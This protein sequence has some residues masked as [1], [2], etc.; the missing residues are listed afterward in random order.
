MTSLWRH[1]EFK[2][3]TEKHFWIWRVQVVLHATLDVYKSW[4]AKVVR[5]TKRPSTDRVKL[6]S[7][8]LNLI[9]IE[10]FKASR[11]GEH[12]SVIDRLK[13]KAKEA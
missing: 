12:P 6:D 9:V 2:T 1:N 10:F 5:G 11:E 8:I 4:D 7:A 13:A 3:K